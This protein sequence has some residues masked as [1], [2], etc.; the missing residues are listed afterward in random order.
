M[1][2]RITLTAAVAISAVG[3]L[4]A[5]ASAWDRASSTTDRLML[6][7]V[8]VVVMLGAHWLPALTRS[9]DGLA[10]GLL[11]GALTMYG[12]AAYFAEAGHRTGQARADAVQPSQQAA[13][14]Q[15]QLGAIKA[16]PL[17]A[18]AADLAAARGQ[19]AQA[20]LV[21]QRCQQ[22]HQSKCGSSQAATDKAAAMVQALEVEFDQA[23]RAEQLLDQL[24]IAAGHV[25]SQRAARQSDP[26]A[27]SVAALLAVRPEL[28]QSV[29]WTLYAGMLELITAVLSWHALTPTSTHH[30]TRHTTEGL[31]GIRA[32]AGRART[33]GAGS[34]AQLPD[35]DG[36]APTWLEQACRLA[37]TGRAPQAR[38]TGPG[39][40][41]IPGDRNIEVRQR[42]GG[43]HRGR[44]SPETQQEPKPIRRRNTT[45]H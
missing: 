11:C 38:Q 2:R 30:E 1:R 24:S 14:L 41:A 7:A 20:T 12:H 32:A 43:R 22:L 6:A 37:L 13:A 15:A 27:A 26:I 40:A 34:A 10:I 21:Q 36:H 19:L 28:V 16:R 29:I 33:A 4:I 5:C 23:R 18:V 44:E 35:P 45:S 9:A 3:V 8:S 42:R 39:D 17:A 31:R 25:D